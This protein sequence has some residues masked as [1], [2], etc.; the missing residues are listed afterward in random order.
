MQLSVLLHL[1]RLK[2]EAFPDKRAELYREYFKTVIDRDV[3]KSPDLRRNRDD[4][5]TLHEVIGFAIHSRAEGDKAGGRLARPALLN[6]VRGWFSA[7]GRREGLGETLFKIGEER[8]GLIVALTGEGVNTEYGF[9]IQPVREYFAAAFIT[10]KFENAHELF[11]LM[12]R[13]SFWKEVARFLAGLRRAT[14]RADL[15]ARARSL[16]SDAENG[17]RSEG[18]KLIYQL[19]QEGVFNSPGHV[20]RDALSFLLDSLIPPKTS[21]QVVVE[22]LA[23]DLG[24]LVSACDSDEPR[25]KLAAIIKSSTSLQDR[26]SISRLWSVANSVFGPDELID[27]QDSHPSDPNLEAMIRL[28][29]PPQSGKSVAAELERRGILQSIPIEALAGHWFAAGQ[30]DSQSRNL[31]LT[32][33]HQQRLIEEFAFAALPVNTQPDW[34]ESPYPVW[35]LGGLLS[36]LSRSIA[37]RKRGEVNLPATADYSGVSAECAGPLSELISLA[38]S[39]ALEEL[40]A[41]RALNRLLQ[42]MADHLSDESIMGLVSAKCAGILLTYAQGAEPFRFEGEVVYSYGSGRK[43]RTDSKGWRALK[44]AL[45][46]M[47]EAGIAKT[48]DRIGRPLTS[49]LFSGGLY[50]NLPSHI[51]HNGEWKSILRLIIQ[52]T[53]GEKA[54]TPEWIDRVPIHHY[55]LAGVLKDE[56][57]YEILEVLSTHRLVW[58]GLRIELSSAQVAQF[59]DAVRRAPSNAIASAGIYALLSSKIWSHV[60]ETLLSK[61]MAAPPGASTAPENIF[62][63]SQIYGRPPIALTEV[64]RRIVSGKLEVSSPSMATAAANFLDQRSSANL[65]PLRELAVFP[66]GPWLIR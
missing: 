33:Q 8:L 37:K 49:S 41:H 30:V 6:L 52:R 3:E 65:K 22:E 38:K 16:D 24:A 40:P 25:R 43:V 48:R 19:V 57:A 12:I 60:R 5:E 63:L 39:A 11:E 34:C 13:R 9:E 44:S 36:I 42:F 50:H 10:D 23:S 20:H 18:R 59:V 56:N 58:N 29:L 31:A 55:W 35:Q 28:A 21:P 32:R 27:L 51:R 66:Q 14:E 61:M 62:G 47:F 7:E 54:D 17:W 26:R 46:P 15:L 64:A 45:L 53:K 1:I 4:I 2:G